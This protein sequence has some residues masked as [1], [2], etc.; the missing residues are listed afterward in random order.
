MFGLGTALFAT[1][2]IGLWVGSGI[3]DNPLQ[4][5]QEEV[6][7]K[8]KKPA[9][10]PHTIHLDMGLECGLC[11]HDKEQNPLNA[12]AIA[13]LEGPAKLSCVSC[14]NGDHANKDLQK[15]KDVFHA[16]CKNCHKTGYEGKNGPTKCTNCHLKKKKKMIEGC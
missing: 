8:G 12:E 14:H 3:A 10:F 5:P 2:T 7:I 4:A 6:I 11:H 1:I 9:R 15:A 13:S 16:R